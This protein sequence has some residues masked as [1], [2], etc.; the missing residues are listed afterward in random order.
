M[1][2]FCSCNVLILLVSLYWLQHLGLES[3][4]LVFFRLDFVFVVGLCLRHLNFFCDRLVGSYLLFALRSRGSFWGISYFLFTQFGCF[5]F[6]GWV[7]GI[8]SREIG[9]EW[10]IGFP[11]FTHDH[12]P[13]GGG[14]EPQTPPPHPPSPLSWP[15]QDECSE[16][17]VKER[18]PTP[19]L[20][21]PWVHVNNIFIYK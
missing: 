11:S 20:S 3:P 18:N 21:I 9:E 16:T 12:I 6:S 14:L 5:G 17:L 2:V 4:T 8:V 1:G 19:A 13:K 15:N 10:R 7:E